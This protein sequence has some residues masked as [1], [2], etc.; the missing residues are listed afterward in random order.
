M[1]ILDGQSNGT[2]YI[3][4]GHNIGQTKCFFYFIYVRHILPSISCSG[5]A[6]KKG[7]KTHIVLKKSRRMIAIIRSKE[8]LV[9]N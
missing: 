8:G 1:N 5:V 4:R 7:K 9:W 2:S 6:I 3:H